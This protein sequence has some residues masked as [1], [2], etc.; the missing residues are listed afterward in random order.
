MGEQVVVVVD[1][2]PDEVV[3]DMVPPPYLTPTSDS[4]RC[5]GT[6]PPHSPPHL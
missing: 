4:E 1:G 2:A 5:P 6:S 3:W